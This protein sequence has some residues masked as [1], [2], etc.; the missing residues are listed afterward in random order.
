MFQG[1]RD[2][3]AIAGGNCA[4]AQIVPISGEEL[5]AKVKES[6]TLRRSSN[7]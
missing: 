2:V 4:R 5:D 6:M 1:C 3:L 7:D